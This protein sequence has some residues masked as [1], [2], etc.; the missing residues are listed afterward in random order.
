MQYIAFDFE[1]S[2][3]PKGRRN[4]PVTHETLVN[5][6]T[7]RAVSLSAARFSSRGRLTDTFDA[8]IL[9][10]DFTIG[11]QSVAIHGITQERALTEGRPFTDVFIDFMKFIG[12]RTKTIVAHN[13]KFD[14]S[15]LRSEML[16]HGLYP[17]L[18]EDLD[19]QCTMELYRSRYLKPIR[20][21][22][23]Y[24]DLFGRPFENAHNSLAD[25]IACGRVYP[26]L[27]GPMKKLKPLG[28][29]NVIIGASS[30]AAAI[31]CGFRKPNDVID[32]LWKRYSPQTFEGQ[33][34]EDLAET[35]LRSTEATQKILSDAETFK[36]ETSDDVSQ[37]LR[38][39][40]YQLEQTN[41][42]P[43]DVIIAKDHIRKT[44]FT[45]HGTRNE[46][47]SAEPGHRTDDTFYTYDICEIE[48]TRYQIVGRI[49]RIQDNEDG[50]QTIVEIKNR[51]NGLFKKVRDYEAIQCQ[52]YLHMVGDDIRFCR[53]IE[54]FND[55]RRGYLI[56]KN[57]T[58]WNEIII[59]GLKT[60]CEMFHERLS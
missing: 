18:I 44:L 54:Q 39:V 4:L 41:L 28:I 26:Y 8:M 48:G 37:K 6:D 30:V 51:T 11:E 46:Y 36:S 13:A 20:L 1:T 40:Y 25:C 21:G 52:S 31:G 57:D 9:P 23:L 12:P 17:E 59:P 43:K 60:F 2:G 10:T 53:L 7:C 16:R 35:L 49:D 19:F 32:Q 45:N 34:K 47:K 24:E 33:T 55:E 3:L 15:V 14:T 56:E 38:A 42:D 29:P 27:I 50:T 5:Y 58:E 22:V